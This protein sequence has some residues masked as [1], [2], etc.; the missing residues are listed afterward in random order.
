MWKDEDLKDFAKEELFL[1][2]SAEMI[3]MFRWIAHS[4]HSVSPCKQMWT[5]F[6][7]IFLCVLNK[8]IRKWMIIKVWKM[9]III[10]L[11]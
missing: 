8:K 11:T 9:L 5:F 4:N 10:T 7:I 6:D 2:L 1:I 3:G